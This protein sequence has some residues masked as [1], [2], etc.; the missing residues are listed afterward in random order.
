MKYIILCISTLC[1]SA[2]TQASQMSNCQTKESPV[3]TLFN[4]IQFKN[5]SMVCDTMRDLFDQFPYLA[6]FSTKNENGES[7][8]EAINS[9]FEGD[10]E[11]Y[12]KIIELIVDNMPEVEQEQQNI[13]PEAIISNEQ[14]E[15]YLKAKEAEFKKFEQEQ[16]KT[17]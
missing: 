3:E 14:M 13:E 16:C 4:V 11:L 17:Q 15:Q 5:K 12:R 1:M 10:D 2:Y 9:R 7:L 6:S 8:I